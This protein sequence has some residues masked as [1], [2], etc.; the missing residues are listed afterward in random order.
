MKFLK[1]HIIKA[2][3]MLQF[4]SVL[5]FSR[6]KL[7]LIYQM[8]KVG[9]SSVRKSLHACNIFPIHIHRVAPKSSAR[10][11]SQ[12]M[13]QG[14]LPPIDIHMGRMVYKHIFLKKRP[15]K[16]ITLLREPISRNHSA[17]FQNLNLYF[18]NVSADLDI[19]KAIAVFLKDYNHRI[20]LDWFDEEL[21]ESC[22]IDIFQHRFPKKQGWMRI[23][24]RNIDLLILKLEIDDRKKEEVI[25]RFLNITDFKLKK[26]NVGE[27]KTYA[28]TYGLFKQKIVLPPEY[29]EKMCS[30]KYINHFYT[31]AEIERVR[32]KWR[33]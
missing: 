17:F 14:L 24:A 2:L 27:E 20:P 16:I 6:K 15:A 26:A 28:D 25:S 30:S 5:Y 23:K 18:G 11:A 22:G 21:K 12:F 4:F 13:N 7:V 33:K 9:S 3:K 31:E 8:G 19:E 1:Y 32:S 29:V 10:V